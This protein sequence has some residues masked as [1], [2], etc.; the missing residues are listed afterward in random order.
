MGVDVTL[1]VLILIGAVRGWFKGFFLQV[2]GLTAL[3]S[4][5]YLADPIRD[6]ARPHAQ[7]HFPGIRPEL[8]DKLLWWCAAVIAA[9][10]IGGLGKGILKAYRRRSYAE[11]EPN[12]GDQGVG[13][14]FGGLKA[15]LVATFLAAAL[16]KHAPKYVKAGDVVSEQIQTSQALVWTHQYHPADRIWASAPVQSFVAHVRRRG[17]WT[18]AP[19]EN[20]ATA[21]ETADADAPDPAT[22]PARSA[23]ATGHPKTLSLSP[24]ASAALD[25]GSPEFLRQLDQELRRLD[26][27]LNPGEPAKSR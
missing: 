27:A 7:E 15:A 8:L 12:R 17:L 21:A 19:T 6:F 9:L 18:D 22:P 24:K 20:D 16:A 11:P 25:P 14:L 26:E 13:F 4:S 3:L 23:R 5:V 10:V 1:G 2:I